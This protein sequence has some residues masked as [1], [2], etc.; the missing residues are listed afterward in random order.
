M[1]SYWEELH[2]R[3]DGLD[4]TEKPSIFAEE[5]IQ[6]FPE[7]G[8]VLDLG[9]GQ[10]QDSIYFAQA[11]FQV[12]EVK[13][14]Q[15]PYIRPKVHNGNNPEMLFSRLFRDGESFFDIAKKVGLEESFDAELRKMM[16]QGTL[17]KHRK[18]SEARRAKMGVAYLLRAC[19]V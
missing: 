7:R 5:I 16:R 4:W 2:T 15:G 17:K 18:E 8:V 6:Y 12:A 1:A 14:L 10:G 11:G 9:A 13:T 3:Y 19:A